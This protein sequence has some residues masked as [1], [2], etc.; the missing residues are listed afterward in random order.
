MKLF[1]VNFHYIC[2]VIKALHLMDGNQRSAL[3]SDL[4]WYEQNIV[5]PEKLA[6]NSHLYEITKFISM[7]LFFSDIIVSDTF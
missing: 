7:D 1:S 5:L 6:S 4:F 3:N 2:N